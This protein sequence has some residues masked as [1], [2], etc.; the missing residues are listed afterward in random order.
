MFQEDLHR[1]N[2]REYIGFPFAS[3]FGYGTVRSMAK[4]FGILANGGM[5]G[6]KRLLSEKTLNKMAKPAASGPDE[7]LHINV[8][9]GLGYF[10]LPQPLNAVRA[11]SFV[12][13]S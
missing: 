2:W 12:L 6:K 13:I 5:D 8:T 7:I 11:L 3:F 4:L 1:L 10:L 9:Y